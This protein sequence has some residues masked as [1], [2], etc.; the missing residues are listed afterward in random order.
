[1]TD[2]EEMI[3]DEKMLFLMLNTGAKA[4]TAK[5]P[6]DAKAIKRACAQ[7]KRK[8]RPRLG[9]ISHDRT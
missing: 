8:L 2:I 9:W 4:L 7:L 6:Q 5:I 1:M 3:A